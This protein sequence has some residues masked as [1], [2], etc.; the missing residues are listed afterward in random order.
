MSDPVRPPAL[1]F[2]RKASVYDL[3]AH[4]QRDTAAWVAEWLPQ[5]RENAT[6]L[7]FGS[8]TGNFTRHLTRC[9]RTV[10]A[11]DYAGAM[12]AAGRESIPAAR[13]TQRDAWAPQ[14]ETASRDFVASCSLL[15]WAPDP[16][17][18]LTRWHALLKPGG[19]TLS[20][21]Y[22]APSLPEFRHLLPERQPLQ[23][24]TGDEWETCFR[25]AGFRDVRLESCTREYIYPG[26]RALLRQLHGTGAFQIGDPLPLSQ[27]RA[28]IQGYEAAYSRAGGV[29]ATWTF[30]RVQATA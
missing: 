23:W 6:C 14:G 4:V 5:A 11:S 9:F 7:E 15:Q 30:C 1:A 28:L 24:R 20:G 10:E 18:V 17:D 29:V 25:L 27:T 12:V 16:V 2:D 19:E 22:I 13:W 3:H 21:I 8:G 26:A